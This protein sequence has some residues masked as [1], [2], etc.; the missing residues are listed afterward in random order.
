MKRSTSFSSVIV[1]TV[2][3]S[4]FDKLTT[5]NQERLFDHIT[6]FKVDRYGKV[7]DLQFF[8][9]NYQVDRSPWNSHH[10][11][12]EVELPNPASDLEDYKKIRTVM[13]E[14][15][16]RRLNIDLRKL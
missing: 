11:Y 7:T 14:E 16:T 3:L 5:D 1:E 2:Y 6:D 12:V 8:D 4:G 9:F 15:I 13:M 10:A